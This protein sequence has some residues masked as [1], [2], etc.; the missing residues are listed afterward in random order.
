MRQVFRKSL[1]CLQ[2]GA[3]I[4]VC[5]KVPKIERNESIGDIGEQC[6]KLFQH[7]LERAAGTW[8]WTDS[9]MILFTGSFLLTLTQKKSAPVTG[10]D[11]R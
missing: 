2:K 3:K 1:S 4:I 5:T 8:L 6:F 11:S 7:N 10:A 9:Y